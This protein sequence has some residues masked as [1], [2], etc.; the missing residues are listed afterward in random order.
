MILR[1]RDFQWS[2]TF[3]LAFTLAAVA[4]TVGPRM[5]FVVTPFACAGSNCDRRWV[6]TS[7]RVFP[8]RYGFQMVGVNTC[9]ISASMVK[10]N[11]VGNWP[12]QQFIGETM[13]HLVAAIDRDDAIPVRVGGPCPDPTPVRGIDDI[14][15]AESVGGGFAFVVSCRH[16]QVLRVIRCNCPKRN[17]L[18]RG[19]L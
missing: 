1:F 6:H 5:P 7:A 19:G 14:T 11:A 10:V 16:Q 3:S 8:P 4:F 17:R 12:H 13:G 15:F 9:P 18:T 2:P